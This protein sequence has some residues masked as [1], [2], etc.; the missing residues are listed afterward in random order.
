MANTSLRIGN[1][2]W[3]VKESSLLG[4]NVIQDKYVPIE[5]GTVRATTA[6]RVNENGLIEL[7]P[8]DLLTYSEDFSNVAW[9]KTNITV[10]ENSELSPNGIV[11]TE[12]IVDT[13]VN[14]EHYISL[15]QTT[16]ANVVKTFSIFLKKGTQPFA[17]LRNYGNGNEMYFSVV[18]NLDTGI[19]TKTQAGTSAT[20]TAS[21]IINYG[22]GWYRVT[23][24]ASFSSTSTR[25]VLYLV[26]SANPS[27]GTY[28]ESSYLG[29]GINSVI[30]WGAQLEQGSTDTSYFPTTDRLN[31][32]R[33][34]YTSGTASLLVEPQRTNRALYSND[35]NNAY[36]IKNNITI[37]SFNDG[38]IDGE[39]YYEITCDGTL[40][41]LKGIKN[42]WLN[43][44]AN[45]YTLSIIAKAG[46]SSTFVIGTRAN[47]T[48]SGFSAIFNLSNGTIIS[49]NQGTAKI[50]DYGNGWYRCFFTVV[51]PSTY[52]DYASL[53]FGHPF[54]A[55]A[56]SSIFITAVQSEIGSYATSYIP[57][58]ASTVTRNLD[59]ISKTGISSLINGLSGTL[60]L[61]SKSLAN[62]GTTKYFS[63]NDGTTNNEIVF[64]YSSSSNGV[65]IRYI[66]GGLAQADWGFTIA[67][68]LQFNKFAFTWQLNKFELW[69]NGAKI[70]S[71]TSGNV[72][73]SFNRL[74]FQRSNGTINFNSNVK[75]LQIYKTALTDAECIAL[76]TL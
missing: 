75:Q 64:N 14:N 61:E 15:S 46:T 12:T 41:T 20:S 30:A 25:A 39:K 48:A 22:N 10:T 33:I 73:T 38:I 6:T 58:V 53:F 27:I 54:G 68:A 23:A 56:D 59:L 45:T 50:E 72:S 2:K 36:W 7:V 40:G 16:T 9:T 11:N 28:G 42:N 5:M 24:T 63:L 34:D 19:I 32:P 71:D 60:F 37:Q 67:N 17:M 43:A 69:Y 76:T 29:N 1:G 57:T 8:K 66:I 70:I 35:F 21:S 26:N 44:V 47:L 74:D 52:T 65:A 49:E 31:I 18:V 55:S 51:N 4:Y 62:D 13:A 3:A